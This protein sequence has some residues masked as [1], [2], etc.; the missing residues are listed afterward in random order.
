[1]SK[2]NKKNLPKNFEEIL[3]KG[4]LKEIKEI[5]ANCDLNAR[6]GLAKQTAIAF[7]TC[8]SSIIKWLVKQGAD[9]KIQ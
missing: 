8:P 5:F 6:G 7:A 9:K 1:M 4:N 2:L 3:K